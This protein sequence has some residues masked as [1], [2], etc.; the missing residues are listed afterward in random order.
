MPRPR[1]TNIHLRSPETGSRF[2]LQQGQPSSEAP[3]DELFPPGVLP[4]RMTGDQRIDAYTVGY[5]HWLQANDRPVRV[6][7]GALNSTLVT[8]RSGYDFTVLAWNVLVVD[9]TAGAAT[10]NSLFPIYVRIERSSGSTW[11]TGNPN[12]HALRCLLGG[13][14]NGFFFPGF[15]PLPL[16]VNANEALRMTFRNDAAVDVDLFISMYGRRRLRS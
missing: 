7:A 5:G 2:E 10:P 6:L 11:Y 12:F 8:N 4:A 16:M 1:A 9:T 3:Y 15:L 13:V 14:N